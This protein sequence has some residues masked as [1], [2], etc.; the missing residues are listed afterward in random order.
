V[1]CPKCFDGRDIPKTLCGTCHGEGHVCP[2][3]RDQM[4]KCTC[5]V[6]EQDDEEDDDDFHAGDDS[7]DPWGEDE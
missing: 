4:S 1:I 3:C 2:I 6:S 5:G 7:Y